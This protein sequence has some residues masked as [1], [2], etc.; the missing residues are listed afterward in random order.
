MI[1]S[2][3]EVVRGLAN[4]V[5][6]ILTVNGKTYLASD[7]ITA[8]DFAVAGVVFAYIFNESFA[9]GEKWT[10]AGQALV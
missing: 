10:A 5:E 9:G 2:Y 3:L 7:K 6:R 4:F 8:A 1:L